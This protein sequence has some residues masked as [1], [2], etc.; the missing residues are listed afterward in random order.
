MKKC[1][2]HPWGRTN[3]DGCVVCV[4]TAEAQAMLQ[5]QR[6]KGGKGRREPG[7]F[8]ASTNRERAAMDR[9]LDELTRGKRIPG[10]H[11]GAR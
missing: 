2:V 1:R 4:K 8:N 7:G 10:I 9:F 3:R 5:A 11:V 6:A